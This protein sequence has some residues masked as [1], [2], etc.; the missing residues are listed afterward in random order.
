MIQSGVQPFD[1]Y[2]LH[3]KVVGGVCYALVVRSE[4][5]SLSRRKGV[6]L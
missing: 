3:L 1:Q 6:S 5:R 4:E 2:Q